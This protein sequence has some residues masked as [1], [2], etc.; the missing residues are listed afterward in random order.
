MAKTLPPKNL[1]FGSQATAR[2]TEQFG[3]GTLVDFNNPNYL[4]QLDE[5]KYSKGI[6]GAI[7]IDGTVGIVNAG[8]ENFAKMR[9]DAA[10]TDYLRPHI[11]DYWDATV[12]YNL[13]SYVYDPVTEIVYRSLIQ[14]NT[15][16][17]LTDILFWENTGLTLKT[18]YT[19]PHQDNILVN[20]NFSIWQEGTSFS[21]ITS[22][23]YI[24][25]VY[26]V[27]TGSGGSLNVSQQALTLN[28]QIQTEGT[29]NA[30]HIEQTV[31]GAAFTGIQGEVL[32]INAISTLAGKKVTLSFYT[33]TLGTAPANLTFDFV[34][35]FGSGGS[36]ET[37]TRNQ[38]ALGTSLTGNFQRFT[39][40]ITVPSIVGKTLG[41]NPYA[42]FRIINTATGIYE[43]DITN[44]KLEIGEN[45]TPYIPKSISQEFRDC[46]AQ[47]QNTFN[48]RTYGARLPTS[49]QVGMFGWFSVPMA[50][51]TPRMSIIPGSSLVGALDRIGQAA[52]NLSSISTIIANRVGF[53]SVLNIPSTGSL[54]D[55]Y[56]FSTNILQADARRPVFQ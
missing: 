29:T 37:L 32:G 9:S 54:N 8:N 19:L 12:K 34:Q 17:P 41:T 35:N 51:N 46:H 1:K 48:T 40:T 30:C 21:N 50:S 26:I 5:T 39:K 13:N 53:S 27:R 55:P 10:I 2:P 33:R 22:L 49:T 36:A 4:N 3:I 43:F 31:A 7:A 6:E 25:D 44:I 16:N 28:E 18:I 24:A 42:F 15:G 20:S 56:R 38:V 14:D 11:V 23:R 47:Y 52:V 45:P